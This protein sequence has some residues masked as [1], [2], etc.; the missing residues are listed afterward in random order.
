M[1]YN[2]SKLWEIQF[3]GYHEF[4]YFWDFASNEEAQRDY[5]R[6]LDIVGIDENGLHETKMTESMIESNINDNRR[7]LA[8]IKNQHIVFLFTRFENVMQETIECLICNKPEKI[9]DIIKFDSSYQEVLGFSIKE[10]IRY[11]SKEEYI[12]VMSKKLSS[13]LLSGKPST[14]IKRLR[15]ILKFEEIDASVLDELMIKRNNIVHEGKVYDI[16]LKELGLY[17]EAI[18]KLLTTL[19]FA[20]I[21]VGIEVIDKGA[22][23]SDSTLDEETSLHAD[24][25]YIRG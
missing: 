23:L 20:L 9:L 4:R 15:A 7:A 16:D 22:L 1:K 10:F 25:V 21:N 11:E 3:F 8:L 18:E 24:A 19:A 2:F 17:Y 6:K 14:V 13:K 5:Y 12:A